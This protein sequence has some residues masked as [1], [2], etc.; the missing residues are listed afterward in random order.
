VLA[1]LL[2][3]LA[4]PV[5]LV[6]RAPGADLCADCRG[7]LP[8]LEG[9]LCPRCA[10]PRPCGARCPA[11]GAAF[12]RAWSPV[13]YAD[14]ARK[15]V[16]ALKH[17]RAVAAVDVMAAQVAAGMPADLVQAVT[18]VPVPA[19]PARVRHRGFDPAERLAAAV[20]RRTGLPVRRC[21]RRA[22]DAAGQAGASRVT[23]LRAERLA[24]GARRYA[25]VPVRALLVDD[26][27]TTGATLG[28]AAGVLRD[29][30]SLWVGAV[31]YARTM[32]GVAVP[33]TDKRGS[34][35]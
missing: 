5:C 6:C 8:W 20:A 17:A 29:A 18:V 30:G 10:L 3:L 1:R 15:L 35:D 4:P 31:T 19:H 34:P 14:G 27:H 32:P 9:P 11:A 22:S 12:D 28:A 16:L 7:A 13:A 23:R 26:V 2:A 33:S 25:V 21:L 24:I